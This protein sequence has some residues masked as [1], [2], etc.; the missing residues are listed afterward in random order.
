[1]VSSFKINTSLLTSSILPP[2]KQYQ[3]IMRENDD[4]ATAWLIQKIAEAGFQ[5][6]TLLR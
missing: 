2:S 1:M 4:I 3:W 6:L 5:Q